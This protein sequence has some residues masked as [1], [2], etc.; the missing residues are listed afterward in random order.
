[1]LS[2][3]AWADRPAQLRW[4]WGSNPTQVAQQ[5]QQLGW[6]PLYPLRRTAES[7]HLSQFSF[8]Q[9]QTYR[10]SESI[11]TCIFRN[12][13]LVRVYLLTRGTGA[14]SMVC[15]FNTAYRQLTPTA[16]VD[17]SSGTHVEQALLNDTQVFTI[18]PGRPL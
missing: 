17:P 13:K 12:N 6:E 14:K 4:G 7:Q 15:L 16:W 11:R 5:V 10:G 3:P 2:V 1:M 9:P 8:R 18:S